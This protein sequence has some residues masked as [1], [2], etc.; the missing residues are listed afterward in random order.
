M[1]DD[2]CIKYVTPNFC[3]NYGLLWGCQTIYLS[4]NQFSTPF[5]E[6]NLKR[7]NRIIIH[8]YDQ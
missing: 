5:Y 3:V 2:P 1:P 7:V 8:K 4:L 6:D